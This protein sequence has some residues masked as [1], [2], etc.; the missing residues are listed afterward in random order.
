MPI[1][2]YK[3][4]EKPINGNSTVRSNCNYKLN[5]FT[6]LFH[7]IILS[8]DAIDDFFFILSYVM[9]SLYFSVF[10]FSDTFLS[11]FFIMEISYL[12]LILLI[13][14]IFLLIF[15]LIEILS[16][17][18]IILTLV[19]LQCYANFYLSIYFFTIRIRCFLFSSTL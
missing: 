18:S 1:D 12:I 5:F 15:F 14:L 11:I 2:R 4:N 17:I 6:G 19:S 13:L 9:L 3:L 7:W 8:F 16:A 10:L